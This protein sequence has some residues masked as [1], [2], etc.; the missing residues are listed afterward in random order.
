MAPEPPQTGDQ[1]KNRHDQ[2]SQANRRNSPL[3][4]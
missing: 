4:D 1:K 2:P 3:R